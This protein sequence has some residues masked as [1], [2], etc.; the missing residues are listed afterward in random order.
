QSRPV[1]G[2]CA[3]QIVQ[4]IMHDRKPFAYA[5]I[6]RQLGFCPGVEMGGRLPAHMLAAGGK[7]IRTVSELRDALQ[8]PRA[9]ATVW[10]RMSTT[11]LGSATGQRD[12]ASLAVDVAALQRTDFGATLA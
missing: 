6:E 12:G 4:L 7:Q 8:N 5:R 3:P 11:V 2:G 1:G 10:K 9:H